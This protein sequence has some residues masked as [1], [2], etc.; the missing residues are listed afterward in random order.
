MMSLCVD[1]G[2]RASSPAVLVFL[3]HNPES[4][5][6]PFYTVQLTRWA[7]QSRCTPPQGVVARRLGL[8]RYKVAPQLTKALFEH[9]FLAMA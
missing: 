1:A 2:A 5:H 4:C 6:G 9:R 7:G 3:A 8:Q